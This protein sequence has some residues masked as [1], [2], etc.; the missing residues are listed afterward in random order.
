M[1]IHNNITNEAIRFENSQYN[2]N[3]IKKYNVI[4]SLPIK[5]SKL[6][7]SD[8]QKIDSSPF[9]VVWLL[10]IERLLKILPS[11]FV[12]KNYTLLDVGCGSGISTI[13]FYKQSKFNNIVGFDFSKKLI[14][15]A[16]RNKKNLFTIGEN[17]NQKNLNFINCDAVDFKINQKVCI[18][19]FNP[20]GCKTVLKFIKNNIFILKKTNSYLLYANDLCINEIS[21]LAKV[22]KRDSFFNLS[23]YQF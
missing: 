1:Y 3:W 18:F 13:Y 22:Y 21:K 2:I 14:E 16:E 6:D 10:N 4:K 11:N 5:A 15:S 23:V 19:M 8:N 12:Y 9:M 7:V 20:F 17:E